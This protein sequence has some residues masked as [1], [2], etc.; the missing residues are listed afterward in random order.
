MFSLFNEACACFLLSTH[1]GKVHVIIHLRAYSLCILEE[2]LYAREGLSSVI[3]RPY[4]LC[5][6]SFWWQAEEKDTLLIPTRLQS[7]DIE[8]SGYIRECDVIWSS[9][10]RR[11]WQMGSGDSRVELGGE[12]NST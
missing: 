1:V 3:S 11:P 8:C 7:S 12:R 9:E 5:G 10:M 2:L 6:T 4:T